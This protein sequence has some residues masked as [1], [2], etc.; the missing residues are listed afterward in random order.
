MSKIV[1][2]VNPEFC[3]ELV[4]SIPYAYHLHKNNQLEKVIT[5][6]GMKPFSYFCDNV[7]ERY[8]E[9]NIDN[10]SNGVQNLPNSWLHHNAMAV[11][12]KDYKELTEDQRNKV[13][14]VLDYS[15]WDVPDYLN[16]FKNDRFKFDK[17]MIVI[18]NQYNFESNWVSMSK[19]WNP[20][21]YFDI[22]CLYE[23]FEYLTNKGYSVLYKRPKNTE[24]AVDENEKRTLT[25]HPQNNIKLEA[26]VEGVGVINDYELTKHYDD[27]YL[28]DDIVEQNPNYTY[29]EIQL[30]LFAN[31]KGFVSV[32][33]GSGILTGYFKKPNILYCTI[34]R[35]KSPH[36]WSKDSYYHKISDNQAIPV[37]DDCEEIYKRGRQDYTE[38][39]QKIKETF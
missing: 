10:F 30:M 7:E 33:G 15:E 31:S 18:A 14:G 25:L 29:N 38:L 23:M 9:R 24:F 22:K 2:D 39:L 13:Q 35:E 12:G 26:N 6:K 36:Y 16:H 27:V 8:N 37:I 21:R 34:G 5:C 17:P 11:Y 32:S 19:S 28:I 3:Y 20:H 4:C 1:I